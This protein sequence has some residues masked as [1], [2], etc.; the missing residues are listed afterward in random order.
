MINLDDMKSKR[1]FHWFTYYAPPWEMK[2][3]FRKGIFDFSRVLHQTRDGTAFAELSRG[4]PSNEYEY[5]GPIFN[6]PA[7]LFPNS[8]PR[9]SMTGLRHGDL[10]VQVTRPPLDEERF[11]QAYSERTADKRVRSR[12]RVISRSDLHLERAL[13]TALKLHFLAR[14]SRNAVDLRT[15]EKTDLGSVLLTA[16]TDLSR[17]A[18]VDFRT[19]NSAC[20]KPSWCI[21][22]KLKQEFRDRTAGYLSF[23]PDLSGRFAGVSA[24]IVW[25]QGGFET[26]FFAWALRHKFIEI[27]LPMLSEP[28][29][30]HFLMAEWTVPKLPPRPTS[31]Q[32]FEEIQTEPHILFHATR[33]TRSGS[34]WRIADRILGL[35]QIPQNSV[36]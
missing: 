27:V 13:I 9:E 11:E 7:D 16:G 22:H 33:D 36:S 19:N 5:V 24:L 15:R 8:R 2:E 4:F 3:S 30:F 18:S 20:Y 34:T 29:Q 25:G 12:G 21:E 14:C 32:P 26:L 23:V 31:L 1:R 28:K 10:I 35:E 6:L 17:Y